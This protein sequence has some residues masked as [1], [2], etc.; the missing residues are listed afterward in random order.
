MNFATPSF[1]GFLLLVYV[2]YWRLGR[3]AQNV[4][5]LVASLFF[6]GYWDWRFLPLILG[7]GLVDYVVGLQL[8]KTD[9]K[10]RRQRWLAV[11]L[12]ANL[13]TLG[14][15]K[16]L[17]FLVD[18]TQSFL[19]TIGLHS[20]PYSLDIIL[21]LGISFY[22]F[23][24]LSYTIDVYRRTLEPT[25]DLVQF[26]A[27]VTFFPQL[28]AGPIERA[29][30]L[31]EQLAKN[32]AFHWNAAADGCRQMLWGFFKKMVVA[33]S[34]AAYVDAAYANPAATTGWQL[35]W[36]TYFFA[37][38]IYCDFSGY[39]DIAIGCARLFDF[40]LM[41]NFAY[42]YFAVGIADFWRRWHISLT[43]WFR[44]YVYIPLG[45]RRVSRG[46]YARNIFIVFLLS[47]VWH[48]AN[49]TFV[50]WGLVHWLLF[51]VALGYGR[52]RPAP[53]T[54]SRLGYGQAL[55]RALLIFHLVT[56]AWIFFRANSL[57]DAVVVIDGIAAAITGEAMVLPPLR[58]VAVCGAMLAVEWL[59]RKRA[60][61]LDLG[62][63]RAPLRWLIYYAVL[64][65]I[66]LLSSL[67]TVSFIYFQF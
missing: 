33:D 14:V 65:S 47:G 11:S 34:L 24:T 66:L 21:P 64:A 16:Y 8:A 45:G 18:S 50:I 59:Q 46:T 41:R 63:L 30:N 51:M 2:L 36:A 13:G 9:D 19:T 39:S 48:G 7:S 20:S 60:H 58:L 6:Y 44:D 12:V 31:L 54:Q 40:R 3:R 42:P 23:Q 56:F 35:T 4:L 57:T 55:L 49:W 26:L 17:G 43:T 32:R 28:V 37:I 22:T 10:R 29:K 52:L 1:L 15:F 25:R 67:Q 61:G 5:L 38:Q 27:F 62:R 53:S